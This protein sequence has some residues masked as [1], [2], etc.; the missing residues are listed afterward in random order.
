MVL[1]WLADGGAVVTTQDFHGVLGPATHERGWRTRASRS[2][3]P[4]TS[5][6]AVSLGF[7]VGRRNAE[8]ETA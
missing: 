6:P 4:T 8:K 2:I 3:P 1:P 5:T 7:A